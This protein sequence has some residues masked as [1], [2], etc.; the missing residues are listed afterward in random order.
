[1][2]GTWTKGLT[3]SNKSTEGL[4]LPNHQTRRLPQSDDERDLHTLTST[5]HATLSPTNSPRVH[6][7][8]DHAILSGL[9]SSS[10]SSYIVP[11]SKFKNWSNIEYIDLLTAPL[12]EL[13]IR[14]CSSHLVDHFH[15]SNF[16]QNY[17]IHFIDYFKFHH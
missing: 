11:I 14:I 5:F 4:I 1:M 3:V 16:S 6:L 13:F 17:L 8:P 2:R 15:L 9:V 10:N 7:L 12:L